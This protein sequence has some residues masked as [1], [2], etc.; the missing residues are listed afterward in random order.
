MPFNAFVVYNSA[1]NNLIAGFGLTQA[2]AD[3][4]ALEDDDWVAH[5]G[6]VQDIPDL[7][8]SDGDWRFDVV[9]ARVRPVLVSFTPIQLLQQ[10]IAA[11]HNQLLAWSQALILEGVGH[12]AHQIA[13]GHN[14][15]AGGHLANYLVAHNYRTPGRDPWTI[16]QRRVYFQQMA[17]GSSDVTDPYSFFVALHADEDHLIDE[18][19]GPVLWVNPDTGGR[20]T[21][22]DAISA[23]DMA[24]LDATQLPSQSIIG[25]LWI[26]GV[27][28]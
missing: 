14:Y 24:E 11:G 28:A 6:Q 10:D 19:N 16:M 18:P 7:T 8:R 23:T 17:F 9:T 27:N 1:V 22:A 21:L 5:Q 3:A 12:P 2:Q 15:I 26:S 4:R 13:L 25:A 20:V